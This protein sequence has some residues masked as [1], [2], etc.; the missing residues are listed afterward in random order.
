MSVKKPKLN[1]SGVYKKIYKYYI[2]YDFYHIR[3]S[4]SRQLGDLRI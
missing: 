3:L 4:G 1:N 2:F